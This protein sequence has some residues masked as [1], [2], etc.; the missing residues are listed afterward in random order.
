MH[1]KKNFGK[2]SKLFLEFNIFTLQLFST[3]IVQQSLF[4]GP[5]FN[6]RCSAVIIQQS[7]FKQFKF[8]FLYF[9][10]F[11]WTI[12]YHT[13]MHTFSSKLAKNICQFRVRVNCSKCN[14]SNLDCSTLFLKKSSARQKNVNCSTKKFIT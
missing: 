8:C 11:H 5:L 6:S 4:N 3:V 7:S 13:Y 12:K 1:K 9:K 10:F 14:C 2:F